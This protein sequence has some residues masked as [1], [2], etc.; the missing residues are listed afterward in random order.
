M[1]IKE[2]VRLTGIP[3]RTIRFYEERGML[4]VKKERRNGRNYHEFTQENVEELQRIVILRQARFSLEEILVM[5]RMPK[6]IGEIV[7]GNLC[8]LEAEQQQ[9]SRLTQ[10]KDMASAADWKELAQRVEEA[11]RCNPGYQPQLR[12]GYG[13][14]E[15]PQEKEAAIAAHRK[16]QNRQWHWGTCL[17][18]GLSVFFFV[19]SLVF[20]ILLY[21]ASRS[22]PTVYQQEMPPEPQD[23]TENYLYYRLDEG[24]ARSDRDGM[25]QEIIYETRNSFQFRLSQDKVFILDGTQLF[26]VNADGSGKYQYPPAFYTEYMNKDPNGGLFLLSEDSVFILEGDDQGNRALVRVPL[27]GSPHEKLDMDL[28]GYANLSGWIWD[29]ILYVFRTF[30]GSPNVDTSNDGFY[31]EILEYNLEQHEVS[32]VHTPFSVTSAQGLYFDDSQGYLVAPQGNLIWVTPEYLAGSVL[33]TYAETILAM[34]G[35]SLLLIAEEDQGIHYYLENI[36]TGVQTSL[37]Q[38]YGTIQPYLNFTEKGLRIGPG[39][40][41]V[42]P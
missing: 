36:H 26:S 41:A 13:D 33:K 10:S 37:P 14:P 38:I 27:D 19:I 7:R 11:L 34:Y 32:I 9:L 5:K 39:M 22:A 6:K 8:R 28:D 42:Y 31:S 4:D 12:F 40:Y 30:V 1:K 18:L 17:F 25:H 16:K 15:S 2:V 29:D 3:E 23:S 20:G 21:G 24:L 35:D